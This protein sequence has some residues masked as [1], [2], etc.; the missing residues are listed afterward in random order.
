M[1]DT[2]LGIALWQA[3]GLLG[4]ALTA[5]VAG[6]LVL[7]ITRATG[8]RM[9]SRTANAWD[10][11][12]LADLALPAGIAS[13]AAAGLAFVGALALPP[14]TRLAVDRT[15]QMFVIGA[16]ALGL[17][18]L[19]YLAGQVIED[20]AVAA[21]AGAPDAEPRLR[22]LRT[23]ILVLRRLVGIA[24]GVVATALMLVQFEVVRSV[25]VSLL[26]S[27]GMAGIVLGLAAQRSIATLLAGLQL[28]LTQPIRIG[29]T[30]IV[31]G[32]WGWI[33]EITLTYVVLRVWDERRLVIPITRFLEQPFQNW[34]MRSPQL[35]GAVTLRADHRLPIQSVRA[36]LR[37]ILQDHPMWDGRV[38]G[39]QV[40][41]ADE[42]SIEVRALVSAADAGKQWD[43]CCDVRERLLA[44]LREEE[45]GRYLPLGRVE[46]SS[47]IGSSAAAD[48]GGPRG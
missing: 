11:R 10:D 8:R 7:W 4:V 2:V 15:L 25:G 34:T 20:R 44:W 48:G 30:V 42:R 45:G 3:A 28:S 35:L 9:A 39:V 47:R 16:G 21:A 17:V 1:T 6:A 41:A 38:E 18:R 26:A 24:I 27:A 12:L 22:G 23:Q 32:E 33:E 31:E 5:F 43:L 29:D 19:V 46:V 13:G 14:D 37:G 40:T 36:A